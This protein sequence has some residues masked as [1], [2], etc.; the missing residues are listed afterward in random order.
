MIC[1]KAG[2][3]LVADLKDKMAYRDVME[4]RSMN[5]SYYHL[6]EGHLPRTRVIKRYQNRKLYDTKQSRYVTLDDIARMVRHQHI[7][8]VVIDNET[9]TDITAFIFTQIIFEGEK[10]DGQYVPV[11]IL[12][13]IIRNGNLS[14]YLSKLTGDPQIQ[15]SVRKYVYNLIRKKGPN[16]YHNQSVPKNH[17]TKPSA[18]RLTPGH[19]NILITPQVTNHIHSTRVDQ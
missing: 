1:E 5:L 2:G 8:L 10:K 13:E 19:Q 3:Y 12:G 16:P 7:H 11:S 17:I 4:Q 18:E 9:K 6:P 15:G 14:A